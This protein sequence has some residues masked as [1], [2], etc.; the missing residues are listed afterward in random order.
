M[1]DVADLP[2][3]YR[4]TPAGPIAEL[5]NVSEAMQMTQA[6]L[7]EH[8]QQVEQ[9]LIAQAMEATGGVVAKAARMLSMQRTTLVEKIGKYNIAV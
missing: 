7:K 2:A 4:D 3:K 1:I 9:S 6:N 5:N 8:L